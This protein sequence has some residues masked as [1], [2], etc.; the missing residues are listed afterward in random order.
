M[1]I[2]LWVSG[3]HPYHWSVYNLESKSF[4]FFQILIKCI[5]KLGR[6]LKI[7]I[8]RL[9]QYI[10]III[11]TFYSIPNK[12]SILVITTVKTLCRK[13]LF[14]SVDWIVT[15]FQRIHFEKRK[16]EKKR[17]KKN[18]FIVEKHGKHSLIFV[19]IININNRSCWCTYSWYDLMRTCLW[20]S[21]QNF[22]TSVQQKETHGTNS[23]WGTV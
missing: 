7:H 19:I 5:N 16:K 23:S 17:K 22:T 13:I 12:N 6:Y 3:V 14:L 1:T 8:I 4:F 10:Y 11:I 9:C 21:N 15:C 18:N 20:F 2:S